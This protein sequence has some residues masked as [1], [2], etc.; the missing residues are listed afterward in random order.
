M[1]HK[2]VHPH[3]THWRARFVQAACFFACMLVAL[4]QIA[5]AAPSPLQPNVPPDWQTYN[6]SIYAYQISYPSSWHLWGGDPR[7]TQYLSNY[8]QKAGGDHFPGTGTDA[9]VEISVFQKSPAEA[10]YDWLRREDADLWPGGPN[11]GEPWTPPVVERNSIVSGLPAVVLHWA[12]TAPRSES[13]YLDAG[14]AVYEVNGVWSTGFDGNLV[15]QILASY[16]VTGAANFAQTAI[17]H[18][19][20]QTVP[21]V[22]APSA[23]LNLPMKID[24][25]GGGMPTIAMNGGGVNTWFDHDANA[26]YYCDNALR[27]YDGM[28]FSPN[29]CSTNNTGSCQTSVSCYSGHPGIDFSTHGQ[30][31]VRVY[32]ADTGTISFYS[33]SVCGTGLEINTTENGYAVTMRY[34]HL[35]SRDFSS[36]T[37]YKGEPIGTSGCT[38]TG[39]R[40][41]HLHFEVYRI[42]SSSHKRVDPFGWSGGGSDPT[43][44]AI[45]YF[46][47]SNPPSFIG[48]P[49]Y[50]VNPIL[51]S[52][53][54]GPLT[55]FYG[56]SYWYSSTNGATATWNAPVITGK[57]CYGAE[58]W[59]PSNHATITTNYDIITIDGSGDRSVLVYQNDNTSWVTVYDGYSSGSAI[60]YVQVTAASGAETGAAKAWFQC[61]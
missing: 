35:T 8:D 51:S 46:W 23:G 38:G 26:D 61:Y 12:S 7:E 43:P 56:V 50:T 11:D 39:C 4:P 1:P 47:S 9:K 60:E 21:L 25:A 54:T 5:H 20:R 15:K 27:R 45:G 41:A 13:V 37:V 30:L 53:W 3:M 57:S 18:P 58:V 2:D 22:G 59:I 55:D 29:W 19:A 31:G 44:Y 14:P 33:N 34:C 6:N 17:P 40:G 16:R 36:G 48:G 42:V 10:V 28:N 24:Y 49:L 32:A 52:G